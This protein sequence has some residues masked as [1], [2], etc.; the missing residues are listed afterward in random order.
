MS[1]ASML[2]R[3]ALVALIA[4]ALT[5]CGG[6]GGGGGDDGDPSP[7]TKFT[8]TIV[9]AD[10]GMVKA[11]SG[12]IDG[13]VITIPAG[14]LA[15]DT[16]VT[17]EPGTDVTTTEYFLVGPAVLATPAGL[18]FSSP[19]TVGVPV[20]ATRIPTGKGTTDV[21]VLRQDSAGKVIVLM[22]KSGGQYMTRA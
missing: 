13:A 1:R 4:V 20:D 7:Q 2:G 16:D 11:T 12:P 18:S 14:A 3:G 17:I 22:P 8:E 21:V 15:A 9:A 19:A 6:G 10:G 5:A